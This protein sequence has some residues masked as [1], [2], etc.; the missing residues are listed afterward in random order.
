MPMIIKMMAT[1][2]RR[3]S[4]TWTMTFHSRSLSSFFHLSMLALLVST[5][6]LFPAGFVLVFLLAVE[7]LPVSFL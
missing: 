6:A 3:P 1:K 5:P 2:T 7:G 4:R